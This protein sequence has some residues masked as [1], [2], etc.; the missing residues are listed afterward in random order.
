MSLP[1]LLPTFSSLITI[2]T[3]YTPQRITPTGKGIHLG[4]VLSGVKLQADRNKQDMSN[5]R[6][7]VNA[8]F[9]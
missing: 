8:R 9:L 1:P 3:F 5:N 7:I 6:F 2:I 4:D